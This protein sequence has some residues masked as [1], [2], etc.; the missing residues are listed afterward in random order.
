MANNF[1][2]RRSHHN[3]TIRDNMYHITAFEEEMDREAKKKARFDIKKFKNTNLMHFAQ[4]T[5]G[6]NNGRDINKR[7][8]G[9]P[10]TTQ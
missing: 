4:I 8:I 7:Q 5:E 2:S 9:N 3:N 6:S 10:M 1:N